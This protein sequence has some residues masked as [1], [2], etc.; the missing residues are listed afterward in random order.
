MEENR[1]SETELAAELTAAWL[2]NPNTRAA[3]DQVQTFLRAIHRELVALGRGEGATAQVP[4][5]RSQDA[6]AVSVRKSLASPDFIIS[7]IDGKPYRTLRQHLR[8]H[9]LTPD[10][11]RQRFDLKSDYPR[12]PPTILYCDAKR[13]NGLG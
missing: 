2:H 13:Q 5:P 4:A 3:P 8:G 7:M 10:Q 1:A 9:G 6:P 12:S 11:Y